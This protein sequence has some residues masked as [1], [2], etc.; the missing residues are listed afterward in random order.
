MQPTFSWEAIYGNDASTVLDVANSYDYD[1]DHAFL[2]AKTNGELFHVYGECFVTLSVH[3]GKIEASLTQFDRALDV[4]RQCMEEP[5]QPRELLGIY[6]G[7]F[8]LSH[9]AVANEFPIDR[10][11]AVAA[12]MADSGLDW[13]SADEKADELGA[14]YAWFRKRGDRTRNAG[15]MTSVE[16][17][18]WC[19]KFAHVLVSSR[20]TVTPA[21]VMASLP[22]VADIIE[23]DMVFDAV[24][25]CG[26]WTHLNPFL[27]IAQVCE[28]LGE[29]QQT[30]AYTAAALETD[31]TKAGT[32][33][34]TSHIHAYLM[35]GRAHVALGRVAEGAASFESAAEEAH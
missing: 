21:E 15:P 22:S 2:H 6:Q 28:K 18:G 19:A 34:P 8:V 9:L 31:L 10:R 23:A 7:M 20:P 11:E 5:E 12:M 26:I 14:L 3:F 24:G 33:L 17:I 16:G 13:E 4:L 35:Q 32:K 25:S 1:L 29:H 30:L 27:Y